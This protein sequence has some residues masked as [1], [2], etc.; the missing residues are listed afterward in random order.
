VRE[1]AVDGDHRCA[2]GVEGVDDLGVVD[3]LE[4]DRGDAEVG[5]LDMRVMWQSGQGPAVTL[6]LALALKTRWARSGGR[7]SRPERSAYRVRAVRDGVH[8]SFVRERKELSADVRAALDA[9]A[10]G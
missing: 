5:V 1:R 3:A 2:A 8:R 10:G 6:G 7:R 4:L 9:G